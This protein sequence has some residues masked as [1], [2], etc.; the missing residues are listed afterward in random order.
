MTIPTPNLH[1]DQEAVVG[2]W[3]LLEVV[4][5]RDDGVIEHPMGLNPTGILVYDQHGNMTGQ[6]MR[7]GR[8]PF[9]P[10][11]SR[12]EDAALF[13]EALDGY[14]AYF[15]RY[16]LD[17]ARKIIVHHVEGSMFPN[18]VGGKQYRQYH[19]QGNRL[20]LSAGF[21][22]DGRSRVTRLEWQKL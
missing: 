7:P 20:T 14:I 17:P 4:T 13:R 5:E 18:W 9:P 10:G 16:T 22:K 8:T 3:R 21:E 1:P 6:V 15:G 11:S 19:L 12:L 2:S